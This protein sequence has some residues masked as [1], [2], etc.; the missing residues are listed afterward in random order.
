[1]A[2]LVLAL[3]AIA[4]AAAGDKPEPAGPPLPPEKWAPAEIA[5]ARAECTRLLAGQRVLSEALGPIRE[6]MCGTPAPL[7]LKG[8]DQAPERAVTFEQEPVVSCKLA[9]A[10]A[11][12][13]AE[14]VQPEAKKYLR[15][16]IAGMVTVASYDCRSRYGDQN[17][18]LSEH[19]F[20]NA[21]DVSEFIT[22]K[23]E[24]IA[25]EAAW[26][27]N[28]DRAAFLHAI[29]EG[30]CRIFGTALGPEANDAHR[31]HFH[32]DMKE[33]RQPLCDF[34]PE[35]LKA[36]EEAKKHPPA[37]PS[38]A[39][40]KALWDKADSNHDGMLA[41]DEAKKFI[42]V[43][44]AKE[45]RYT[46]KGLGILDRTIFMIACKDGVFIGGK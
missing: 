22:E 30:A 9:A 32:L 46:S 28:G 44:K 4:G 5:A 45:S 17:Q 16:R 7:R 6:G 23:G 25:I 33:R 14:S 43:L 13:T 27:A 12:W 10:L 20:V 24:R 2:G 11:R 31:N 37:K 35:Q 39:E 19:A 29:H 15:T 34:S 18:R 1:M 3:G 36:R 41:G 26:R 40:C 8:L 21:L 42:D 38:E